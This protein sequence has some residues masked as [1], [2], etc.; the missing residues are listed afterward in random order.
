[1]C[2]LISIHAPRG[3]SDYSLSGGSVSMPYFNPRSPRGERPV[4]DA[5][6]RFGVVISIHAPRGGSDSGIFPILAIAYLDFNPRS[7]RGERQ[8][9][10][11]KEVQHGKFQST[12]PA[13]GATFFHLFSCARIVISIHAPRGGSDADGLH[14]QNDLGFQSTLPAGGATR[15]APSL[16]SW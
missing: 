8:K 5:T 13:G 1:M 11:K 12:L 9:C 14:Q 16:H 7:P 15:N 4:L 2:T 10:D 6:K 3:G